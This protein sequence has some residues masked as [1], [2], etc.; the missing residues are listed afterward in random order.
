ILIWRERE[1]YRTIDLAIQILAKLGRRSEAALP[2]IRSLV[3][4]HGNDA[5]YASIRNAA[6]EA[7]AKIEADLRND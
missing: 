6:R 3:T 2:H 5:T 7:I 4:F 1:S